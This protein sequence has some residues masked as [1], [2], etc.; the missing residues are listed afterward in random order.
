MRLSPGCFL[1]LFAGLFHLRFH[2]GD[3]GSERKIGHS[4]RMVLF[5]KVVF[6]VGFGLV[7]TA[8]L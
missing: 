3:V 5:L 8:L 4:L 1:H 6:A 7:M 2:L